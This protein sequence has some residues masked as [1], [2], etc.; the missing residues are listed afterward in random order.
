MY[1]SYGSGKKKR[2]GE[3]ERERKY[4][5][6]TGNNNKFFWKSSII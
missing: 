3:R 2:E 5:K 6:I 4:F 1:L